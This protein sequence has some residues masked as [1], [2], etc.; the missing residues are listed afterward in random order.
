MEAEGA[1]QVEVEGKD[2]K[3]HHTAVLDVSM[4]REFLTPHLMHTYIPLHGVFHVLIP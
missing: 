4:A 2:D 1:K 3:R